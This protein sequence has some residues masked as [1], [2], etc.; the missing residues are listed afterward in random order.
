LSTHVNLYGLPLS[1]S[2]SLSSP[3]TPETRSHV[4]GDG[5]AA[6]RIA[7]GLLGREV[8]EFA[9]DWPRIE[10]LRRIG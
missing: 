3:S 7:A 4:Y 2:T 1:E 9:R 5:H 10:G 8:D 6:E